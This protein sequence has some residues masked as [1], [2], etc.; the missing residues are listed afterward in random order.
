FLQ[1]PRSA[2]DGVTITTHVLDTTHDAQNLGVD[3]PSVPETQFRR[4][5]VLTGVPGDIRYRALL[6]VYGYPG[7]YSAIVRVRDDST[8]AFLSSQTLALN[9]SDVAYLQLPM[10]GLAQRSRIEV[11]TGQTTDPPIWA[12]ITLTNNTTESVTTITPD[13]AMT[14]EVH[15]TALAAGHWGQGGACMYVSTPSPS[16]P[17]NCSN[18]L[19]V[20]T[21]CG[22]GTFTLPVIDPD[23]HF[24]TDGNVPTGAFPKTAS[25][26]HLSG[27]VLDG[28]VA[29]LI[30]G[31][32]APVPLVYGSTTPCSGG[33]ACP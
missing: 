15:S 23:G 3:I 30:P 21:E 17:S 8:G 24:E 16:C 19:S 1:I 22:W 18:L 9:G 11:T 31:Y 20:T 28:A 27:L 32:S 10:S 6:R 26:A 25:N 14:P 4:A 29:L 7:S 5:V 33:I 2:A 13:L 12:F